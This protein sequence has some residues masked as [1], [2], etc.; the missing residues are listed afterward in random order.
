MR[1]YGIGRS[2]TYDLWYDYLTYLTYDLLYDLLSAQQIYTVQSFK[3]QANYKHL[4]QT[5]INT[6]FFY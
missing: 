4:I 2:K 5:G 6:F 3:I 1:L